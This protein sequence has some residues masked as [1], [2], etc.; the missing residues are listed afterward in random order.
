MIDPVTSDRAIHRVLF[1]LLAAALLFLQLLPLSTMPSRVPGPDLLLC[2]AFAW[3]QRRPDYLPPLLFAGVFLTADMLLMRPPGLW[4]ALALG[5]GEFLRSRHNTSTELSFPAEWAFTAVVIGAI[6][7][8][9]VLVLNLLAVDHA[10]PAMAFVQAIMTVAVYPAV[11]F[12][13]RS[14]FNLRRLTK[15]EMDTQRMQR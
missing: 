12:L 8:A 5:G 3:L 6:T 10:R 13:C 9:Y 7:T 14:V 2:L 4:T 15:A 11:V 1:V